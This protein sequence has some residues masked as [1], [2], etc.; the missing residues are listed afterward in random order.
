[1]DAV[2]VYDTA[3]VTGQELAALVALGAADLGLAVP[4]ADTWQI[5][6]DALGEGY[7][8]PSDEGMAAI[9]L[10]AR[11]EGVLLDPVYTAKAFGQ[12][13]RDVREGAID[14]DRDVVFVHTGG[15]PGLFAYTGAFPT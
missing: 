8:V 6:D 12:L 10:L 1:V 13:L 15:S 3:E 14:E 9:E 5:R 2:C 11:T 7:G 4:D